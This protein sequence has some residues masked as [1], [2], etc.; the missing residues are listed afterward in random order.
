MIFHMSEIPFKHLLL[1]NLRKC[2]PVP[3][4]LYSTYINL[5]KSKLSCSDGEEL[6]NTMEPLIDVCFAQNESSNCQMTNNFVQSMTN[7][8]YGTSRKNYRELRQWKSVGNGISSTIP[9]SDF[10]LRLLTYNILAQNLLE[11]HSYLYNYHNKNALSWEGRKP[12]IQQEIIEAGANVICIQEMQLDHL[13][14]FL[15]PFKANGFDYLYKKRTN[16]MGDGLLLLFRRNQF[17]LVDYVYVEYNQ[18]SSDIL[19]RDNVGIVAK[20]SLKESPETHIV[21]STT[22]LLYNPKRSDVRLAQTQVLFAEVERLSFI[23]NTRDGPKYH[24]IIVCGDF[25]LQPFTGVYKFITDGSFQ[26]LG[27]GRELQENSG[28]RRLNN[29]LIPSCLLITDNCQHFNV[30]ARRL[31]GSG[32]GHTMLYSRESNCNQNRKC[33]EHMLTNEVDINSSDYQKIAIIDGEYA[34]FSSGALSHPFKLK[35]VY[36]HVK[37]NGELEASTH[38]DEW[39][40][41]DYI[42][43]TDIE[44]LDRYRLPTVAE[45]RQLPHIPNFV[46]GSDHLCLGATFKLK[47]RAL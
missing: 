43:Y 23:E 41:V 7:F 21:I 38:Q 2:A 11:T 20:F 32:D 17:K 22:H 9:E 6:G 16:E 44:L 40:T 27:K 28:F 39:I 8:Q 45:C 24:P 30:L 5:L 35:S 46:V 42:F 10:I 29:T 12:L 47:K 37:N 31:R 34:T 25:N 15:L 33:L 3:E 36:S 18:T 4:A 19:N 14:E 1:G 26:Y 13:E